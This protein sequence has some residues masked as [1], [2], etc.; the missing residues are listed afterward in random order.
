[1]LLTR[2][3]ARCG[4]S[5]QRSI[6][7]TATL[8]GL[9]TEDHVSIM[10]YAY[11]SNAGELLR[12]LSDY[13]FSEYKISEQQVKF[14]IQEVAIASHHATSKGPTKA[15]LGNVLFWSAPALT[16]NRRSGVLVWL[17]KTS[18]KAGLRR[19]YGERVD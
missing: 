4:L 2:W 19:L 7:E 16:L 10:T 6:R 9:M 14:L 5:R 13:D 12:S 15:F 18:L 17:T 1:M 3:S 8:R 11:S